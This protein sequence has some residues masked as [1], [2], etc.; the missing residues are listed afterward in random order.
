MKT[1]CPACGTTLSLDVLIAH[2]GARDAVAAAFKISGEL[3]NAL[4]R[5]IGLFRPGVNNLTMDRVGKL[6]NE[7]LP[8]IQAERVTRHR[9]EHK[10]PPAAWVWAIDQ[11]LLAREQGRLKTPLTS[12]GWLFQV[13]ASWP[14]E[15]EAPAKPAQAN[16][17]ETR[18]D[19]AKAALKQWRNGDGE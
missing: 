15:S 10:A 18:L 16:A 19:G 11:A 8:L 1:R 2:D 14:G 12:H 4:L 5:Y 9:L 17:K 3:G 7:L 13:I 6:L